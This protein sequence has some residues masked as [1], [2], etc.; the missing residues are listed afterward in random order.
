MGGG[1]R[2]ISPSE[3]RAL[4]GAPEGPLGGLPPERRQELRPTEAIPGQ[5]PV[6][7]TSLSGPDVDYEGHF[8]WQRRWIVKEVV[9]L[10]RWS[11][12]RVRPI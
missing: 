4:A 2:I 5:G 7:E 8:A 12:V 11:T 10:C 1:K 9:R 3:A 6:V